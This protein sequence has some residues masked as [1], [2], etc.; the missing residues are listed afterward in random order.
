MIN[1]RIISKILGQL[2]LIEVLMLLACTVFAWLRGEA[3]VYAFGISAA[4]TEGAALAMIYLGRGTD[5]TMSRRDAYL[6]VS[7]VWVVFSIF[8]ALPFLFS[9]ALQ[10]PVDA[11]FETMSGFTTTG[12]SLIDDVEALSCALLF[13]RSLT[14][15]IGGLGIVFFTIAVIPSMVGGKVRVFAAEA[16][17]PMRTTLHPRLSTTGRWIWGIYATLTAACALAFWLEGMTGF[18]AVNYA[19]TV[20]ATGG[21]ATHNEVTGF[22]H[23]AA[24]DFTTVAFMFS[25]GVSFTLL[26]LVLFKSRWRDLLDNPEL[27]F[28]VWMVIAAT[29]V[30]AAALWHTGAYGV[31]EAVRY[32]LYQVV[33]FITTT[34]VFNDDVGQWPHVTWAVL[35]LCMFV[36]GCS[37]STAGGFKCIRVVLLVRIVRNEMRRLIHPTAVLPTRAGNVSLDYSHQVSLLS[38]LVAYFGLCFVTYF[39]MLLT[40]VDSTNSIT[41]AFSCASNVGPSLATGIGPAMSWDVLPQAVKLLLTLLML[42]GRL[43]ILSVLVLFTRAFWK[44][45]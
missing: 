6:V 37:G 19:M 12:A 45:R 1:W 13:W 28:Y 11:F 7:A 36:G 24:I 42:M 34:G 15:W 3:D 25:C 43:E 20:A 23:S 32:A 4:I 27:R 5:A 29:A 8:G 18:D 10:Q 16:T 26:Y 30:I 38:F 39:A 35:A 17:G 9:G 33:A 22:Y 40:G 21:F 31:V 44:D 2:L 14:Q 41:I